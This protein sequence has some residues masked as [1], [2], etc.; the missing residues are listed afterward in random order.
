MKYDVGLMFR[1]YSFVLLEIDIILLKFDLFLLPNRVK[2]FLL[3]LGNNLIELLWKID[4]LTVFF[5]Y[6]FCI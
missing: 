1:M 5:L 4:M 3:F 2:Y 6:I